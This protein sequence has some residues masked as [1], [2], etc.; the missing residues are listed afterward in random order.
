MPLSQVRQTRYY[1]P[2]TVLSA[3]NDIN[4]AGAGA[5]LLPLIMQATGKQPAKLAGL[6]LVLL[7]GC[8]RWC[9]LLVVK[10]PKCHIKRQRRL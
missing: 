6:L 10:L 3:V 4:A 1:R 5:P 9:S 2:K 8:V 7:E